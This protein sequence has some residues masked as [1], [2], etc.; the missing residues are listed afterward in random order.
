[1]QGQGANNRSY[2]TGIY[3]LL[4]GDTFS[5]FHRIQSDEMWHY[6][7]GSHPLEVLVIHPDGRLQE[8]YLGPDPTQG[9]SFQAVVPAGAWFASR[10]LKA[11]TAEAYALVGCTVAPGFDFADFELASAQSL[12]AQYPQHTQ[13]IK[14]LC[15]LS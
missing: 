8:L 15:R 10:V 13:L 5:A 4:T 9:Q 1:M 6:Y 12:S 2:A 7:T 11:T 3:F 14:S